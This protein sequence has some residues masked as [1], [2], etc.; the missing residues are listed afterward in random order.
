M[1]GMLAMLT[2]SLMVLALVGGLAACSSDDPAPADTTTGGTDVTGGT[3][4]DTGG[5][6]DATGGTMDMTLTAAECE[7]QASTLLDAT[8]KSC[9][10]G[11]LPTEVVACK[12]GC[13]G[14]I[15]CIAT[16]CDANT[17]PTTCAT[18]TCSAELAATGDFGAS[19]TAAGPA[20]TACTDMCTPQNTDND[21]STDAD[22]GM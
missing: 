6:T 10:C 4:S 11:M 19:A 20:F 2:R 22:A 8:C 14:L 5:T 3:T 16:Q 1:N 9:L 18:S 17:D 7:A 12:D 21:A 13:V 15:N